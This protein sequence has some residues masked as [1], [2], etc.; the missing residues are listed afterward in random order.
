M[1]PGS[2]DGEAMAPS[3]VDAF[4][5]FFVA[6]A[7]VAGALIGLLFVAISVAGDRLSDNHR[8]RVKAVATL[9][10]FTN[11]LAVSLLALDP[12]VHIGAATI[13]VAVVGLLFVAASLLSFVRLHEIAARD[14]RLL[15]GLLVIFVLQ[16]IVG[17]R[18]AG[19][20]TRGE[21][22][23]VSI[24]VVICFLVGIARAWELVGAPD[25][26][27]AGELRALLRRSRDD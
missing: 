27:I 24:L 16:L 14:I 26:G 3:P 13:A 17:I 20:A 2:Y 6:S 18:M 9:T 7:G 11:A 25:I 19:T 10:A 21:L 22:S 5:D 15:V 12:V 1:G 4:H 23:E 8:D